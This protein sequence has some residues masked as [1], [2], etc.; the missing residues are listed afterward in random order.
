MGYPNQN[1]TKT[2]CLYFDDLDTEIHSQSL[3]YYLS[4]ES[5]L[6]PKNTNSLKLKEMQELLEKEKN[7]HKKI[8]LDYQKISDKINND[9]DQIEKS[10]SKD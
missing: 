5:M 10:K 8:R 9:F 6:N 7:L 3:K 2:L 1:I 4:D